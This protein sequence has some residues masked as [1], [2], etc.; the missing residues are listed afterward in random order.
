MMSY[1]DKYLR[2]LIVA[3]ALML[4]FAVAL[5]FAEP[6]ER[7]QTIQGCLSVMGYDVGP[8]DGQIG[9]KTT[10]AFQAYAAK[11]FGPNWRTIPQSTMID[12]FTAECRLAVKAYKAGL[13]ATRS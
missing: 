4:L 13:L 2:R 11:R 1:H 8:L 10:K 3:M 5:A 6:S 7:V 12:W 9:P